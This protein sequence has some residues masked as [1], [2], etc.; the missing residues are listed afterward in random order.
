MSELTNTP[1][2]FTLF[3]RSSS[4]SMATKFYHTLNFLFLFN[5][6]VCIVTRAQNKYE[7]GRLFITVKPSKTNTIGEVTSVCY[8]KVSLIQGSY[9]FLKVNLTHN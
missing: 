7:V 5:Y 8:K 4:V 9:Y 1:F 6:V 2:V 3:V